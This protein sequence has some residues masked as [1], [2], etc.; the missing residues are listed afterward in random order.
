MSRSS[1]FWLLLTAIAI[2]LVT[3]LAPLEKTLGTSARIIYLHG[4]WVWSAM[5]TILAAGAVG[6]AALLARREVLHAWSRALGRAG[7]VL[8]VTFLPMSM[9]VMQ[10]S[11]NGIYLDEPRFRI[12]FNFAVVGTFLQVGLSFFTPVWASLAN[13]LYSAALFLAMRSVETI[14]HPDAPI[15]NTD[16]TGIQVFFAVLVILILLLAWQIARLFYLWE[17]GRHETNG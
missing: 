12:P 14:L 13:L 15:L 6:L 17:V 9:Y 7:I 5:I 11:W 3:A 4:A 1:F 8:W 16:A 2:F 10:I